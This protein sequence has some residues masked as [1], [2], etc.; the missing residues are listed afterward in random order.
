MATVAE[1][2]AFLEERGVEILT[3]VDKQAEAREFYVLNK[4]VVSPKTY[5]EKYSEYKIIISPDNHG[6]ILKYLKENGIDEKNIV[7]PFKKIIHPV[8]V[9]DKRFSELVDKYFMEAEEND[10]EPVASIFTIMYNT[11]EWMLRRAIE[12]VL[13]QSY[14]N[15]SYLIIDNGSTDESEKI[16]KEYADIDSRI[17]YVRLKKNVPWGDANL[18]FTLRNNIKTKYVAMV[19]SDDYYEKDFLKRSIEIAENDEADI[20]QVNTLTYGDRGFR[21]NYFAHYLG[22]D[23]CLDKE[24]KMSF[25][26]K[27]II[28]VP[29]WGKLYRTE[30]FSKLID[31]MLDC[32]SDYERDREYCLDTSWMSYLVVNA[33][34]VSLCDDILH[35]RTWRPGSSEHSDNHSSKWLTSILRSF[36]CV[37]ETGIDPDRLAVFEEAQLIWL[38]GL[39]RDDIGMSIFLPEDLEDFRVKEYLKRPVCDRYKGL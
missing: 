31:K 27:R 25:F 32:P 8:I 17:T 22:K 37:R 1:I 19:D 15:L 38:F 20:V 10:D 5:L 39:L 6:E 28:N 13:R 34:R 21:Y 30:L 18:L 11:P 3:F 35:V 26:L 29:V 14:T 33:N 36:R 2:A 24:E 9:G 16:A 7:T 23:V 12:S 4:V